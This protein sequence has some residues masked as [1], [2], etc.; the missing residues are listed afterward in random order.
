MAKQVDEKSFAGFKSELDLFTLPPTQVAIE[1][2]YWSEYY[3]QNPVTSTGPYRISVPKDSFMMDLN[4]NYLYVKLK[5]VNADGTEIAVGGD[6]SYPVVPINNLC[7]SFCQRVI[8]KLSD[9]EIE[10]CGGL[11][12]YKAYIETLLNYGREAKRTHLQLG[13][14]YKDEPTKFRDLGSKAMRQRGAPF[15]QNKGV[16]LLAPIHCDLFKQDRYLLSDCELSIEIHRSDDKFLLMS[17][18]TEF[19]VIVE[20]LRW[21]VWK[22]KPQDSLGLAIENVL[23][24][25][26]TAKYPVR[27]VKMVTRHLAA[28][29]QTIIENSIFSGQLPRRVAVVMV[30]AAAFN[31]T[32]I[33][34]PFQFENCNVSEIALKYGDEYVPRYPLRCDWHDYKYSFPYM[35]LYEG[36]DMANSDRGANISY[37]DFRQGYT[38]FLFDLSPDNVDVGAMQLIREGE[39]SLYMQL[40]DPLSATQYPQGVEI[41]IYGEFDNLVSIDRNRT[42]FFD[43]AI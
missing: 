29:S 1:K 43:Y 20:D 4:K 27:R 18:G 40:R 15:Y 42:P 7:S 10:N 11:Y 31:G 14:F 35:Y 25:Q 6:G 2:G 39:L 17:D 32:W 16:E 8:L 9:K 3:P 19:K 41:V 23:E 21:Y 36:C 26:N 34:N 12:A 28:N 5:I 22:I 38:V 37:E 24:K 30:D 33:K 13:L